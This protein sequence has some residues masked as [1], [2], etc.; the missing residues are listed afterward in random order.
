MNVERIV[1][2]YR[3]T[4]I[5][6]RYITHEEIEGFLNKL[7]LV[8][9]VSVVGISVQGR[10]VKAVSAGNGKTK[11]MMWSQMHGNESTTTKAVVDFLNFLHSKEKI[12][13]LLRDYFTFLIVPMV[14]PDGA[15]AYTRTNANKV[16]LN[17]DMLE[18]SQ[19]E[20]RVLHKLLVDFQPD[21]AFN[22]HDQRTIFGVG[23]TG[24]PA[25]MSFLAPSFDKARSVNANRHQAMQL[26]AE[27]NACMQTLIPGQ[28]GRFDDVFNL[29]CVGDY[30]Q[31]KGV[32]TILF[33]AGHYPEDYQREKTR[34]VLLYAI[35]TAC[36]AIV[37]GKYKQNSIEEYLKLPEN[38][39]NFQDLLLR[40]VWSK[41]N[42]KK[43]SVFVQYE[44]RLEYKQIKFIPII[45]SFCNKE[46]KF[47]HQII[48]E[49][50]YFR[51]FDVNLKDRIGVNMFKS[52][53][54][55][56]ICVNEMLKWV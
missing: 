12:A 43:Y 32:V 13:L 46:F 9:K 8:F 24:K 37:K 23:D 5:Q 7:S 17:R 51:N 6:G 28:V 15:H 45:S 44:E 26:I 27:I 40:E 55:G 4:P 31:S 10:A 29:N 1:C 35:L 22:L 54:F 52:V 49:K 50:L 18:L 56:S 11:L 38:K 53:D 36:K 47:A 19:P 42:G 21:Y 20:S 25:T 30:F 39:K 3:Y 14:N 48:D 2:K 33:E 34:E 16:D 41:K